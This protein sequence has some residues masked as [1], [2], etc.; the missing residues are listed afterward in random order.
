MESKRTVKCP[1]C[2][3]NAIFVDSSVVY[4]RSYGMMWLCSDCNA[5]VGVHN[6]TDKPL[7]T[8]AN[9]PLREAR[10]KA[11]TAFDLLWKSGKIKRSSAYEWMMETMRLNSANAHIGSFT[12]EQCEKLVELLAKI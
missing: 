8:L 10:V 7:G 12:V 5:Y 6:G 9:K 3:K 11:H 1:C 4:R 2:G